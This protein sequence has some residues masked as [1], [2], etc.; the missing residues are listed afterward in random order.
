M[1]GRRGRV[2][3]ARKI[4]HGAGSERTTGFR[5]LAYGLHIVAGSVGDHCVRFVRNGAE[6][7][8]E[9]IDT[10]VMAVG[11]RPNRSLAAALEE[12]GVPV[13]IVGDAD[14]PSDYVKA[15]RQGAEAGR[16]L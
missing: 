9:N 3:V 11:A 10:V 16:T 5:P 7:V 4:P 1:G 14:A 6:E 2:C 8:L 15:I 12:L 13:L